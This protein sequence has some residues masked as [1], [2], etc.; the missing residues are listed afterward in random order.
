M[1]KIEDVSEAIA[2][3]TEI[4]AIEEAGIIAQSQCPQ[5]KIP[6]KGAMV[7]IRFVWRGTGSLSARISLVRF[8]T[9]NSTIAFC[10]P[11]QI[12]PLYLTLPM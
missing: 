11:S 6:F 8:Q 2:D 1:S 10:S 4:A 5:R 3:E 7:S 12:D 9:S